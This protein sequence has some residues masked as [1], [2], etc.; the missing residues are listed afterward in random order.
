MF[1]KL[2][3][4]ALAAL[5]TA[6]FVIALG[7]LAPQATAATSGNLILNPGAETG[8][9]SVDGQEAVTLPG[10]TIT[11]GTPTIVCYGSPGGYPTSTTPGPTNRGNAFFAGGATGSST[12]EQS[13]D[14]SSA[15]SAIDAGGVTY[16]LSGWLG[17]WS[18]Q[19]DTAGVQAT[20]LGA[21]GSSLGTAQL[22]AV[23]ASD[24]G[25][26][27]EFLQR[28][29]S[30]AVP[31]GTRSIKVDVTY[32]WS[33]G[34]TTDGYVD[35]LSL[36]LSTAVTQPTLS[37]P[38]S[39]VPG[40]DHVFLVYM[41]NE[42]GFPQSVD[43]SNYIYGNSAAPYINNTLL[44]MGTRL[45]A[46][47]ATT[48]PSD[49]N[50]LAIAG[51]SVSGQTSNPAVG[52]VNATNLADRVEAVGKTWKG[53]NEGA[54]GPCDLTTH[55]YT[56]PDDEPFTL[57]N[58][59]ANNSARC[60]AHI[61][62]LT[63]LATD[64]SSTSTTPSFSWIAANDYNDMEAGGIAPGDTWLSQNL[65][66]IFNSPAWKTQ[67]SLLIVTW[68]EAY[69]KSYGPNYP[70]EV[71][72]VVIGSPGTANVGA[73]STTRYNQYSIG[74]T[75]ENALGL[76]PL[77]AN[78]TY[79]QPINDAWTKPV[80]PTLST[81]TP[82][83]PNGSSIT[84]SY[85][86]PAATNSATNWIGI[87][88][89]G[90]TPGNQSSTDWQYAPGTSGSVTFN[91]NYGKGDVSGLLPLQRRLQRAGRTGHHPA[92]VAQGPRP[93]SVVS[94]QRELQPRYPNW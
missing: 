20:F 79:A 55:G 3:P 65:P 27:T 41:E 4:S 34:N 8:E 49:P 80:N 83:V 15:A 93:R 18:S 33:A 53:Y 82:S 91:A 42:D 39:A 13:V 92:Q 40:Y 16:S 9:C 14:V 60:N 46:L 32:T 64:L 57:Y 26:T 37:A 35:N 90:N 85:A 88:K 10:W 63:Q 52:S 29:A 21:S 51:G 71:A 89:Q 36:T 22:P 68:D 62:P 50:Y 1:R 17:G 23:T 54:N 67:R 81:T 12:M 72:G 6:A 43:G 47:Y 70:N 87:Y 28:T 7:P 86:T 24:R 75:I 58:D 44:P 31:V 19:N 38:S 84:F 5:V 77:T 56:Y 45:N 69:T 48:H 11:N 76:S 2:L 74:R 30:A 94:S 73:T 66:T 78:D 61:V 59:V 25:N